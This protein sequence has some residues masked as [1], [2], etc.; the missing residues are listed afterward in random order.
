MKILNFVTTLTFIFLE[1]LSL[2]QKM[3]INGSNWLNR[4]HSFQRFNYIFHRFLVNSDLPKKTQDRLHIFQQIVPI[5]NFAF[6]R[7]TLDNGDVIEANLVIGADGANSM[8]RKSMKTNY[9]FKDYK[10]W[11]VVGTVT[12]EESETRHDIAFQKFMPTG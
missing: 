7:L 12:L 6:A 8:I 10:Q 3:A 4:N 11:G 1:S 2:F 9:S 5:S